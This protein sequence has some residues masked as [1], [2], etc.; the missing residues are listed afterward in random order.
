MK[1]IFLKFLAITLV[2]TAF[3]ACNDDDDNPPIVVINDIM[4][5]YNT[6]TGVFSALDITDGTLTILGSISYNGEPL[7]GLRGIAYNPANG[8]IYASSRA[9]DPY[10]GKIFSIDPVTL[11]ATVIND[12]ANEDWYA[13]AGL[14]ISNGKLLG[15]VYWDEYNYETYSSLVWLEFDGSID[16]VTYLTFEGDDYTF[17]GGMALEFGDTSDELL[18]TDGDEIARLNIDGTVSEI[19][20]L[21]PIGFPPSDTGRGGGGSDLDYIRCLE[22]DNNGTLYGLDRNGV[23]GSINLDTEVFTYITEFDAGGD[24]V[25]LVTIPENIFE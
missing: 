2:F 15:T 7:A 6:D 19:I 22:K 23:F 20:E 12:N 4:V 1:A 10:D 21:T 8:M 11:Q 5:V 25:T 13:I 18:I 16:D 3:V 17:S 9:N 14:Q 24:I